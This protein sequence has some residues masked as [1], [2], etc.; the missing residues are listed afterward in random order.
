MSV[1]EK[2]PSHKGLGSEYWWWTVAN[3]MR[4]PIES[5]KRFDEPRKNWEPIK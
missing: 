3:V 4:T 5:E 1:K 2:I